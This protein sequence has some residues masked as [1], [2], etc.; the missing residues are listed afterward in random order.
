MVTKSNDIRVKIK[1]RIYV[2][3][4]DIIHLRKCY[5]LAYFKE[6]KLIHTKHFTGCMIC[7][8][9]KVRERVGCGKQR[10]ATIPIHTL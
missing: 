1:R 3:M 4:H 5:R 2:E 10:E 6:M 8:D 9:A 7:S